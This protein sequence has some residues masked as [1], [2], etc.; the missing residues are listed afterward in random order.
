MKSDFSES[1]KNASDQATI[2]INSTGIITEW[3]NVAEKFLGFSDVEILGQNISKIIFEEFILNKISNFLTASAEKILFLN[4]VA[5]TKYNHT[6]L[7][8]VELDN[9]V[10]N[11]KSLTDHQVKL[12]FINALNIPD[13]KAIFEAIVSS[14]D[15]AIIS[16]TLDGIITS[17]NSAATKM[18]GYTEQEAFG[19]HI[20]IIIPPDRLEEETFIINQIR[21]GKKI[22]H[23]ETVRISRDGIERLIELSVSPIKNKY[24]NIIGATKVARDISFKKEI[25]ERQARLA[26]IVDSSDDAIISKT[27][28][29]IITSWNHSATRMFGYLES[30]VIGK[31]ISIII[32]PER[33]SEEAVIINNIRNGRKVDHFETVRVTK[34]GHLINISLTVSPIK[35]SKGVI[36]GASKTARDISHRIEMEKQKEIYTKR[37][38]ELNDY[39][40]EF[41][42]MASHEL[43]TPLTVI[44]ANLQI[45]KMKMAENDQDGFVDKTLK[46]TLKLSGLINNLFEVSKIQ[47]GKLELNMVEFDITDLMQ[48]LTTNLQQTTKIHRLKFTAPSSIV[49][50]ADRD[51]I[52]QVIINLLGNALKYMTNPGDII[53]M[54][55]KKEDSVLISVQDSGVGIPENDLENIFLRFYRVSGPA[56]SFS[57]SGIGLYISSEIIK[58]HGGKIWA[59]STL[60]KGS[61]FYFSIPIQPDS[62]KQID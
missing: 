45:L 42:I 52:E 18:F 31:H 40:D 15:D 9:H 37:L 51:K 26:A 5:K 59:E 34:D 22:D 61:T 14:S 35:N 21:S 28:E 16:K 43:K 46:Q 6:I 4:T 32:P 62:V 11:Q 57:G 47:S 20:S 2:K 56:S 27:I 17:W 29:G 49:V 38:R 48:E 24:G 50:M 33:I 54:C 3:S 19:K 39:K 8:N 25:D 58:S 60:K 12:N 41:M 7:V 1:S 10:P 13:E 36:I 44:L 53:I 55:T 30:E 23:F